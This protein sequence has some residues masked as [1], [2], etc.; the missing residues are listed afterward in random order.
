MAE[1]EQNHRH[2]MQT[3]LVDAKLD[4]T[5]RF[6]NERRTGQLCGL[7]IG[8]VGIISGSIIAFNGKQLAGSFIGTAGIGGIVSVFVIGRGKPKQDNTRA[9]LPPE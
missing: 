3:K 5:K 2:T 4:H 8:L 1:K 6:Y 7:T 9:K